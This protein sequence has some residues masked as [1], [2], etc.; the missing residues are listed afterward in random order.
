MA[1]VLSNKI[2]GLFVTQQKLTH[3]FPPHRHGMAEAM[4]YSF[5]HLPLNSA[6]EMPMTRRKKDA[7]PWCWVVG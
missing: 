3:T 5:L 4:T 1:G 2:L 7:E 6:Q